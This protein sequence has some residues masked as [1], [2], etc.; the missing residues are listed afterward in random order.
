MAPVH[1]RDP[2]IVVVVLH[3]HVKNRG[4]GTYTGGTVSGPPARDIIERTLDYMRIPGD[5]GRSA[6]AA[7]P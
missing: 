7:T 4:P 3:H 1:E 5:A 2:E 6:K